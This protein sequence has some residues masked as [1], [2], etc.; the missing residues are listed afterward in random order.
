MEVP[1]PQVPAVTVPVKGDEERSIPAG[2]TSAEAM[3]LLAIN[4]P[5]EIAVKQRNL[6]LQYLSYFKN[7]LVIIL[8][9]AG[10]VSGLSGQAVQAGIIF[11]LWSSSR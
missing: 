5:N 11:F 2:L 4:G 3:R 9:I 6:L 7:P 8:L 1:V 10:F